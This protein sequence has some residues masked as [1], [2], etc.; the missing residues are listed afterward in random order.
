MHKT[1]QYLEWLT[2]HKPALDAFKGITARPQCMPD[3]YKSKSVVDAY[4]RYYIGAKSSIAKW[5]MGNIPT[6][7]EQHTCTPQNNVV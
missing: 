4:R 2:A 1:Q 5:R 6:W 3:E 7:F